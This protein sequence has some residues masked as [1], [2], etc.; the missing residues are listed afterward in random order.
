[1][2]L[3]A[4]PRQILSPSGKLLA[5]LTPSC[6][7]VSPP[8]INLGIFAKGNLML[9]T[10]YLP[11]GVANEE[12]YFSV[13]K[14]ISSTIAGDSSLQDRGVAHYLLSVLFSLV[15]L[16]YSFLLLCPLPKT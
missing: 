4:G 14:K 15:S 2:L 11:L 5:P 13:T 8:E 7:S 16:P 3:C 12:H 10:S 1:M 9:S 6:I